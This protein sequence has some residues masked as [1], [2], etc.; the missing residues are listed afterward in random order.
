MPRIRVI[1][2]DLD[3]TLWD[4][5]QVIGNAERAMRSYLRQH[6]PEVMGL[7]ERGEAAA[8]R[9]RLLRE[10][11]EITHN[12]SVLRETVVF[13][14]LLTTGM[15][16][17]RAVAVASRAFQTF[18]DARHDVIYF[19]HALTTL[20]MLSGTYTMGA[21]SNGNADT[22]TLGLDRYLT[23]SFSA[24]AVGASKPAPA[25]FHAALA[26]T[27]VQ[28]HEAIH[29]GDHLVDDIAGAAGVGMHTIWVNMRGHELEGDVKPS[30]EVAGLDELMEA[31]RAIEGL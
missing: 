22:A 31:I 4:V 10:R 16:E 13:E 8:I 15:A 21:L 12:L 27:A 18:L 9:D 11:P 19:D 20:E 28:P 23:F 17:R 29:V 1:T 5:H 30:A 25:M 24:E 3:N 7:F 2:F 6:A 26:H 14:A